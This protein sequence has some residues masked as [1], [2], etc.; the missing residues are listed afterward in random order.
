MTE[1]SGYVQTPDEALIAEN[2]RLRAE[3][4][5]ARDEAL[6]EAAKWHDAREAL[7]NSFDG[8][9]SGPKTMAKYHADA[10]AD[11]RALKGPSHD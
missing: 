6:E 8:A 2:L 1:Q 7:N 5:A 11:L 10:A 3:L 9:I 4:A